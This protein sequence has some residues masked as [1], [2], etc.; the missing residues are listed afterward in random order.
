MDYSFMVESF[1]AVGLEIKTLRDSDWESYS[2]TYNKF[3]PSIPT[4]VIIPKDVPQVQLSVITASKLGLKIQARSGGHSYASHSNGGWNGSA[5]ID[6]RNFQ[7]IVLNPSGIV[8]VGGG[9]RLGNLSSEIFRQGQRALA[10][11][12][13]AAVGVGG[14]FT[15]GGFGL[16]SRAWGLAMHQIVALDVV[17]ADGDIVE[18]S[19]STHSDLFYA[20]RGAADS[21][22][23]AV[24]FHLRTQPAPRTVIKWAIDMSASMANV[25]SA[26][27]AFKNIQAFSLFSSAMSK[28]VGFVLFFDHDRFSVEGQYLKGEER[29]KS[30]VLPGLLAASP[31]RHKKYVIKNVD[32][33][34][35]L[36]LWAGG[37]L[38][39]GTDY[40]EH[41]AFYAKSTP[42]PHPGLSSEALTNFF[43]NLFRKGPTA[44]VNYF[45]GAQLWGGS[46]SRITGN[47]FIG[48]GPDDAFAH[49]DTMW[50]FQHYATAT[51][52]DVFPQ[53]GVKF[54]ES[55]QASL[56]SGFGACNNYA[57]PLLAPDTA[58]KMYYGNK[59][60]RLK[61]LKSK[62]DPRNVFAHPQSVS[63][64]PFPP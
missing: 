46:E 48:N 38:H 41:H 47:P 14:H 24:G 18:A 29:F 50:M 2:S 17:T 30:L 59:L 33:M 5:V 25:D 16:S 22:G 61:A 9:V 26:V 62:L 1:K 8:R 53:E 44:P 32:Y 35:S 10:H 21:F 15:H 27:E 19:E 45:V 3:V 36:R 13:C 4:V 43:T 7:D 28:D 60:G 20:M 51:D 52:G 64:N 63:P 39:V 57:D 31:D 55:L 54:V 12:T 37:D 11:G 42:V 34:E 58:Q 23:I 49:R 56:G 6:L 40:N